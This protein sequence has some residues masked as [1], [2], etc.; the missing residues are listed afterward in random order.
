[1]PKLTDAKCKTTKSDPNA[2]VL[3]GDG[4]GLYLLAQCWKQLHQ[5]VHDRTTEYFKGGSRK[6]ISKRV[7]LASARHHHLLAVAG[8][9]DSG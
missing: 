3:L 8:N 6:A 7:E 1:M 2:D 5:L 4:N 9:R